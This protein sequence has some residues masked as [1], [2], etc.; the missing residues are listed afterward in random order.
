MT[1]EERLAAIQTILDGGIRR[2]AIGD[3]TIEYDLDALRA[4][5][6]NLV[7]KLSGVSPYKRVVMNR[8]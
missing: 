5:R 3:R 7:R 4:E 8:G 6:E 1:D 2:A